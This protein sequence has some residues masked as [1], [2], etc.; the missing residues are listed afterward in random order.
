MSELTPETLVAATAE[1]IVGAI[2]SLTQHV[3]TEPAP[4]QSAWRSTAGP[5]R[6]RLAHRGLSS[7]RADFN[8][9]NTWFVVAQCLGGGRE[10]EAA[11]GRWF[12]QSPI[13]DEGSRACS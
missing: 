3:F 2:A 8:P 4:P 7:A 9:T 10:P 1:E 13:V 11:R 6:H 5:R 12:L